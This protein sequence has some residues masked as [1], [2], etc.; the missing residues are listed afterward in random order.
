MVELEILTNASGLGSFESSLATMERTRKSTLG[1]GESRAFSIAKKQSVHRKTAC[2]QQ[3][4]ARHRSLSR[5]LLK[6]IESRLAKQGEQVKAFWENKESELLPCA[7][8]RKDKM[9]LGLG[10]EKEIKSCV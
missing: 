6:F 7:G 10:F 2:N 5:D 3:D 4:R 9:W 8:V 1:S